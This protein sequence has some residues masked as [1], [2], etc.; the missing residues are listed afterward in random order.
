LLTHTFDTSTITSER[1]GQNTTCRPNNGADRPDTEDKVFL[2]GVAEVGELTD[3][4]T[5][6]LFV[7]IQRAVGIEFAKVKKAD[8]WHLGVYDK[9]KTI[10]YLT[11]N[12]Q[13]QGCSWWWL[14]TWPG[15][16]TEKFVTRHRLNYLHACAFFPPK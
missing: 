1:R 7:T 13:K 12:S 11:E 6:D 15:S 2:L 16:P 4:H 3:S 8:D 10:D 5:A 14:R 9:S